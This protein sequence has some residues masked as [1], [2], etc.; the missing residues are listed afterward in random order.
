MEQPGNSLAGF[1][2]TLLMA[3]LY[4]YQPAWL[5]NLDLRLYDT[6]LKKGHNAGTGNAVVIVDLDENS[7]QR[8]GQWP[9]P[10]YR[11]ALL[12]KKLQQAGVRAVGM[13]ILFAEPDRTSPAIL[14][15]EL[16]KDLDVD[17]DFAWPARSPARQ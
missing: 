13:D 17:M 2:A 5:R 1:A 3:V 10:R 15:Q 4:V 9:W 12:L 14:Q 11:M 16:K 8:F 6:V 7:L